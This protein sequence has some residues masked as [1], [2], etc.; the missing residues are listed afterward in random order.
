MS[1][2]YSEIKHYWNLNIIPSDVS[3]G[4]V[5]GGVTTRGTE[6][7]G[8]SEKETSEYKG[9]SGTD[10]MLLQEDITSAKGEPKWT[11]GL[12]FNEGLEDY[13]KCLLGKDTSTDLYSYTENTVNKKAVKWVFEKDLVNNTPLPRSTIING[14]SGVGTNA[15]DA[16]VY[17]NALM[18]ELALKIGNDG[19]SVDVSFVSDAVVV[20]Q[21]N[22]SKNYPAEIHKIGLRN[23]KY[24]LAP[25]GTGLYTKWVNGDD[26]SAYQY[27]CLLSYENTW[28]T[29]PSEDQ[30]IGADFGKTQADEGDFSSEATVQVKWN[31]QSNKLIN[32][33]WTGNAETG[34]MV[35]D[36]IIFKEALL[37]MEGALLAVD[38]NS[39]TSDDTDD[40]TYREYCAIYEPKVQVT[41]CTTPE[42][43]EETK[44][45]DVT[46]K[47]V[48]NGSTSPLKVEIVSNLE[49]LHYGTAGSY[50]V[51]S[52]S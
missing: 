34:Y 52:S 16:R 44:T 35:S 13:F 37:V 4:P 15:N 9:H 5:F 26:L 32:E 38:D 23:V 12:V 7:E 48:D 47:L 18:S 49:A 10:T 3:S 51:P 31:P 36:E 28:Q 45:V 17:D 43:G 41:D 27:D 1:T 50:T 30:C 22:P 42:S 6:F 29:N 39:T 8:N 40:T 20:N 46:Y 24:Y 25:Y 33:Y 19:A 21:P 2:S 14:Y 11:Q